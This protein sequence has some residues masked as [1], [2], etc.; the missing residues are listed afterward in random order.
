M[1]NQKDG[2]LE[3]LSDKNSA[4]VLVDYQPTMFSGV[5]SGDKTIIRN[6]A[7]C[8]A[9]AATILNIPV[10]LSTINPQNNG[11][12]LVEV[13]NLFPGQEI[14]AR[15]VPGF[16]AFEDEKTWN[17]AKKTGRKKLVISGLWTSMCFA[18]TAL[19]AIREGYEVYGLMDAAGDSTPDA[20]RY[21]IE[22]MLQ[23]GVIPLT[24]ESLVSEWMHDWANPKAGELVKEVYS[25]Y[26]YMI[27]M[28]RT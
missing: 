25:R 21:G 12:F 18:Y 28:G 14:Y 9:K 1:A 13:T 2:K 23:A 19:H 5:A 17:A 24:V 15:A 20:H 11:N 26:G 10:V 8:A 27:G 22:R 6:A 4:L 16:D 3:L 7:Y